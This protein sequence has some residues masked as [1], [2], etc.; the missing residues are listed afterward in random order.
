[1]FKQ[2]NIISVFNSNGTS[3]NRMIQLTNYKAKCKNVHT[4]IIIKMEHFF[5]MT[6]RDI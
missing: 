3:N 1:M 6:S 4:I 5:D 2:N